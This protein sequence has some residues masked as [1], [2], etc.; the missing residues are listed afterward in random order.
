MDM[1]DYNIIVVFVL[2]VLNRGI[3]MILQSNLSMWSPL[4]S[5][6]ETNNNDMTVKPVRLTVISLLCLF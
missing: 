3:T 4:L 6:P 5:T 1:F 2:R